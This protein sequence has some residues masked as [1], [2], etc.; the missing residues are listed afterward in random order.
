MKRLYEFYWDCGRS[1]SVEGVFIAEE[2]TVNKAIGKEVS[3]G[4]ILG[5]HSDVSGTLDKDDL[6][7]R[8]VSQ[9]TLE[10]IEK[11]FGDTVSGY[12]PLEYIYDEEE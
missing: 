3:F 12:N 4:E 2:E 1:G 8:E 5:K 10:E 7:V 6:S 9:E 11:I